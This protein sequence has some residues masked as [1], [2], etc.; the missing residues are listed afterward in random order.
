M[1]LIQVSVFL[2][3]KPGRLSK[4]CRILSDAGLNIL[5]LS[6]ADTQQFGILRL[7]VQDWQ[8]AKTVLE[9]KGCV[10]NTVEVVAIEIE[11]HPG[12]LEKV[13]RVIEECSLNVEYMYPVTLK[14]EGRG[15]FIFRFENLEEARPALH[16]KDILPVIPETLFAWLTE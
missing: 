8:K 1:K 16:E 15:V 13:L 7:I 6:L 10:V 12:G 5:A 11:D 9:K 2:E 14:R 3:N 4:P